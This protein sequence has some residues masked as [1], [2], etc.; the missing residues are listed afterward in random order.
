MNNQGKNLLRNLSVFSA[1]SIVMGTVIGTGIFLKT[2]VIAQN[3]GNTL[4]ILAV[5]IFSGLLALTGALTYAELG[6]MMPDAGGEY[7]FLKTAY[8]RGTAFLY[9]WI[10]FFLTG[11]SI[12]AYGAAFSIFMNDLYPINSIWFESEFQLLGQEVYW[13]FGLKQILAVAV[14]LF[15]SGINLLGVIWGGNTQIILTGAKIAGIFII[16]AGVFFFSSESN[17]NFFNGS[18]PEPVSPKTVGAGILAALWAYSGWQYL[19]MAAGEIRNPSR[20]IPI[21]LILGLG[22]VIIIYLLINIA[23]FCALPLNEIYSSNST[24]YPFALSVAAKTAQTFLGGSG[25]KFISL[26]FILST[27]GALNGT[28]LTN[29]R[30]PFAMA[31]DRLFFSKFSRLNQKS[32]V[33]VRSIILFT[34]WASLLS[35]TGTFDQLTNLIV[36]TS[37]IFFIITTFSVFILRRK[38]PDAERPYKTF[39][40]PYVPAVFILLTAGIVINSV[41]TNPVEAAMSLLIIVIGLPAYFIFKK[42]FKGNN[43]LNSP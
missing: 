9:G 1:L 29:S 3:T 12:A 5:W 26:I 21:A 15:F 41:Q 10:R 36:I 16:V 11:G 31:S 33:P 34:L 17:C 28:I 43:S 24:K 22:L 19:P 37:S 40:Y 32:R 20:N 39:G 6:A 30:V 23:Y 35:V 8:G 42:T 7:V 25:L 27:I 2:A 4:I 14:I 18:S 38:F 13:H